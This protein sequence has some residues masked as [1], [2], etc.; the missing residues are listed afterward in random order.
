MIDF[1]VWIFN[2]KDSLVLVGV[3]V[4]LYEIG[5]DGEEILIDKFVNINNN[6][7]FFFI[8]CGKKYWLKGI[9]NGFFEVLVEIDMDDFC[10]IGKFIIE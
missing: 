4:E 3:M 8:E 2:F 1:F 9:K 7:F 10:F 6:Q 5:L